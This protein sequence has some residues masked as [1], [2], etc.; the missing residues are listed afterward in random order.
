MY[1]FLCADSAV[2]TRRMTLAWNCSNRLRYSFM[3]SYFI[4]FFMGGG[5]LEWTE[6]HYHCGYLLV[7]CTGL[8]WQMV[9]TVEQFEEW[10][11][12][13][14]NRSTRRKSAPTSLCLCFS[15]SSVIYC[16]VFVL[17]LCFVCVSVLLLYYCHQAK[18]QLQLYIYISYIDQGSRDWPLATARCYCRTNV[19]GTLL[20]WPT[21]HSD[22][23]GLS[24]E[25]DL[26]WASNCVPQ[27]R[28]VSGDEEIQ[29]TPLFKSN[30]ELQFKF[31]L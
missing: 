24:V 28:D 17:C 30:L 20:V 5:E 25:T 8:G 18:A 27:V 31:I 26:L 14:G 11:S 21:T 9:M 2:Q 13:R 6:V 4:Y 7:Y 16:C 29:L 10:L 22:W 3:I 23:R 1:P 15:C 12:G 19:G